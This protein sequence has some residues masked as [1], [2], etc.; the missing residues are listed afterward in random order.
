MGCDIHAYAESK[1]ADGTYTLI[2]NDVF[3]WRSYALFG[4][5]ADI[6]NYSA[7]TP[8]SKP[9]GLPADISP[10]VS[11]E[12]ESWDGDGHNHSW[13]SI[14]E[15]QSFNYDAMTEDRRCMRNGNGGSTCEPGEGIP[16]TYRE[17]LDEGYFKEIDRVAARGAERIVFWFDN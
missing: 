8:I 17:F 11:A 15:L 10:G 5:L 3:G 2:D 4:F 7:V 1:N 9:R 16:Q 14:A 12:N 6:R 13:L